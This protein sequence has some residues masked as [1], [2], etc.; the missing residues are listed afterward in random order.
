MRFR[1]MTTPL[2]GVMEKGSAE[3]I[4]ME[5]LFTL[6][7][8]EYKHLCSEI[9][10]DRYLST[11]ELNSRGKF[12]NLVL[13]EHRP[14]YVTNDRVKGPRA[15]Y[16]RICIGNV[17]QHL[18]SLRD[19][20]AI[21]KICESYNYDPDQETQIREELTNNNL[22]PTR[23]ELHNILRAK[24]VPQFT[25]GRFTLDLS[26]EDN[27]VSRVQRLSRHEEVTC[28][29]N[30][31]GKW[32]TLHLTVPT[33]AHVKTSID[34]KFA[35]PQIYRSKINGKLYVGW[36]YEQKTFH[37]QDTSCVM[38]VDLGLVKPFSAVCIRQDGTISNELVSSR[39]TQRLAEKIARLKKN[40]D[41][42]NRK[43]ERVETL[44]SNPNT[45]RD[46]RWL[47]GKVEHLVN[48][49]YFLAHKLGSERAHLAWLIARDVTTHA[50]YYH[51]QAVK[52]ENLAWL[53]ALG[54][55]WN[56]ADVQDKIHSV[57]VLNSVAVYKVNAKGTSHT[58]PLTKETIKS[59]DK[60]RTA[61]T[62]MGRIDRDRCAALEIATRRGKFFHRKDVRHDSIP[63]DTPEREFTPAPKKDRTKNFPTPKRAKPKVTKKMIYKVREVTKHQNKDCGNILAV[64]SSHS[65]RTPVHAMTTN[66]WQSRNDKN[67]YHNIP[68]LALC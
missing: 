67:Q 9:D 48:A 58:D 35:K 26:M 55:K 43:L 10:S 21:A 27:Y 40:K 33:Y 28:T 56:H 25:P 1:T 52:V 29:V 49:Q 22:F 47:C 20:V 8:K 31:F 18:L 64:C 7:E 19:R 57:A 37:Y 39:E 66:K 15:K 32:T 4:G 54:G 14:V 38:G 12:R 17:R 41:N 36:S 61:S 23:T 42:V 3:Y 34:P 68:R 62:S 53:E 2:E 13:T 65:A 50:A 24:T 63:R 30:V 5:Q 60:N 11:D 46:V 45:C 6:C 51:A 16:F 59:W 44:T